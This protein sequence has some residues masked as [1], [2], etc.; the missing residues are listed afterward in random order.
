MTKSIV[1]LLSSAEQEA[2]N[3]GH[4]YIRINHVGEYT[5]ISTNSEDAPVVADEKTRDTIARLQ[6]FCK[7]HPNAEIPW[8]HYVLHQAIEELKLARGIVGSTKKNKSSFMEAWGEAE[9]NPLQLKPNKVDLKRIM[10][11][12]DWYRASG[13]CICE[14]CGMDYY[15]HP[16]VIRFP[17]L[18]R[19]CNGDLVKL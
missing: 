3:R 10:E 11:D 17:G 13:D 2:R 18:H 6:A 7:G 5:L 15:S 8:P 16:P 1:Q 12:N 9:P 14:K 4:C 19:V